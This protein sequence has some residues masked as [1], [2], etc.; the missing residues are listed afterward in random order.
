MYRIDPSGKSHQRICRSVQ[1]AGLDEF[2]PDA[3]VEAVC[4]DLKHR[5]RNRLLPP[6]PTVRSMVYRGLHPDKSI[7]AMLADLAALLGPEWPAPTDAAW[8]Q[9]RTRLPEKV[10]AQLIRRRARRCRRRF[11]AIYRWHARQVFRADGSTVSMPDEPA[12]VKAFGYARTRHGPSRFPVARI[13]LLELAG[14]N[15]TWDYR[16]GRYT[17]SEEAQLYDMWD[18]LPTGC[19]CLLDR[20]FCSFYNLAKLRHRRIDV[21]TPL[22]ARRD[23]GKLIRQGRLLGK[24]Q[25]RVPLTLAPQLRRKYDDPTLPKV[26]WVRLICVR[27]RRGNKK[28]QLWLVTTL[29]DPKKYPRAQIAHL[30]R[31]RWGIEGRIGELKTTLQMNV[32]RGK[33]PAAV[34]REVASIILGHNLV[35]M[36]IHQSADA[37]LTPAVDISF[38]GAAKTVVAFSSALRYASPAERPKVYTQ[39]LRHIARQRNHHPFDRVEPRL[40]KREVARYAYLREPRWKARL[41]CLS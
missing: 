30:Y 7:A 22:N 24:G 40:I 12:L 31:T 8:C 36:L 27:Y 18:T 19:I 21:V 20:K 16:I 13:T 9:A 25:W 37:T 32:L 26:L 5:W 2:L 17:V 4:R 33:N 34:R 10:L 41:K 6:G 23:P 14:L 35:W 28:A 38:A 1:L 15:V 3:E 39:M 29:M 11:G